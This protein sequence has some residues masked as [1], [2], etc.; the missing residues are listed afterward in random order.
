MW[1]RSIDVDAPA[2]DVWRLLVDTRR[3][4]DWGPTVTA[5]RVDG[6]GSLLT[7]GASGA[8]RTPLG[9]WLPFVVDTWGDGP[10]ERCWSWR[11]VGVAATCHRVTALGRAR[12]RVAMGVPGWAPAYLAVVELGLRRV[13][14]LAESE[15]D[16]VIVP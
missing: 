7:Q 5:A 3:W 11:V 9:L 13:R 8:V 1:W 15:L 2:D 10:A 6:P 14:R 4:P 12:S 16:E